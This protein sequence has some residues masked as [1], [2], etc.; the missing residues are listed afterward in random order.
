[1]PLKKKRVE[2]EYYPDPDE[3]EGAVDSSAPPKTAK[4]YDLMVP[5]GM[6]VK[7]YTP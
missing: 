3:E 6:K 4:F 1:V 2:V 5:A 7:A